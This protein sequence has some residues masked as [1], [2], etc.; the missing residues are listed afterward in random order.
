MVLPISNPKAPRKLAEISVG[1]KVAPSNFWSNLI[2]TNTS[3][4]I[5]PTNIK[6]P[7]TKFEE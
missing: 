1:K 6:G 4:K 2:N 3:P 5:S 7:L